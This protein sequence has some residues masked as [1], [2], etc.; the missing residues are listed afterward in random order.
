M[1]C[2]RSNSQVP[3]L[4]QH[5]SV[6]VSLPPDGTAPISNGSHFQYV[7]KTA[8]TVVSPLTGKR[9]RFNQ[10]GERVEVDAT[11]QSWITFVPHLVRVA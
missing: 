5:V 7:G 11:D 3:T 1:C 10:P 8:L 2:G 6:P 4:L 9:Y